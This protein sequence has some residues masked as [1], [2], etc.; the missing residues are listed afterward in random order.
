MEQ[1]VFSFTSYRDLIRFS[2]QSLPKEGYGTLGKIAR[3]LNVRSSYL[4]QILSGSKNLDLDQALKVADFFNFTPSGKEFFVSLVELGRAG[5]HREKVFLEKRLEQL[6]KL[7]NKVENRLP[8]AT[9]L[10]DHDK[11]IFYSQWY[12]SAVR[13]C[14][15]FTR[16]I[17]D[18][19]DRL[20]LPKEV[21]EEVMS[22]LLA[23]GLCIKTPEGIKT[24]PTRTHEDAKSPFSFRHHQ[25]WRTKCQ[26]YFPRIAADELAFTMP[27]TISASDIPRVK[28]L[29]LETIEKIGE[30]VQKS[31]SE[32][33]TCLNI[34][35]VK[36]T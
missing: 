14:A 17:G 26:E 16:S 36:I 3:L 4:S 10:S 6:R 19:A 11:A 35:W 28:T 24:G 30:I 23:S 34:D 33:L 9:R 22:F 21:V 8:P 25:N 12:Y 7:Y 13:L 20:R 32:E 27:L 29:L 5:T 18:I 1:N 2:M 15:S 31:G